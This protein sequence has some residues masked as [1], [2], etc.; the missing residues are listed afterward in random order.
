VSKRLE[1][2]VAEELAG[3]RIAFL[4]ANEGVEEAELRAP[5]EAVMR[6]GGQPELLAPEAGIVQCFQHVAPSGTAPVDRLI[7]DVEPAEYDALV[8]PGGVVNAD[9]IRTDHHA[10]RF[11]RG[12]FEAGQPVGVICHGPWILTDAGVA[13]GRTLTSWPSLKTDLHNAGANWVDEEVRVDGLLVSSRKPDDLPAFCREV[14][15]VFAAA[16]SRA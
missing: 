5:W 12:C 9:R 2:T 1:R 6:A 14:V 11:V 8:L 15:R 3:L 10:V 7:A 4:V 13:D 16:P